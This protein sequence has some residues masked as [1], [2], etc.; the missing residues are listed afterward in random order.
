MK[1]R[2]GNREGRKEGWATLFRNHLKNV[3]EN[4]K[5]VKPLNR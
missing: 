5:N 2:R 1:R 3:A 4:L